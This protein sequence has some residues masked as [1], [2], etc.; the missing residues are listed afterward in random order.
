MLSVETKCWK[1]EQQY[2][3]LFTAVKSPKPISDSVIL[4]H[5][6]EC[7]SHGFLDREV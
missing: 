3:T 5:I 6:Q 4:A 2:Q 7:D 1:F